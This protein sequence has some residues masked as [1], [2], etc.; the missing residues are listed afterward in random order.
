MLDQFV[1]DCILRER[2]QDGAGQ[3]CEGGEAEMK[4]SEPSAALFPISLSLSGGGSG[5]VESEVESG[6]K[7]QME[8]RCSLICSYFSLSYWDF[9]W[10]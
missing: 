4:H 3:E 7:E 1:K 2:P 5:N 8:K 10:Q 9:D 6:K